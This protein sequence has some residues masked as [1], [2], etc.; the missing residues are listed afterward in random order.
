MGEERIF[1]RQQQGDRIERFFVFWAIIYFGFI[2]KL[3]RA[4]K[5]LGYF[6]PRY[7]SY[8]LIS[9]IIGWATFWAI[10]S[11]TPGHPGR[12]QLPRKTLQPDFSTRWSQYVRQSSIPG[13]VDFFTSV[14]TFI[15]GDE[16]LYLGVKQLC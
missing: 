1:F 15:P 4:A 8:I 9:T 5:I 3:T 16:I 7:T 6:F 14:R 12:Q 10:F 13:Q 2:L 11:Q